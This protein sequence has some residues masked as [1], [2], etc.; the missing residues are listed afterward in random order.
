MTIKNIIRKLRQGFKK[1]K[2]KV[3]NQYNIANEAKTNLELKIKFLTEKAKGTKVNL[4]TIGH[5]KRGKLMN[6]NFICEAKRCET[7]TNS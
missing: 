1:T 5:R 4:R 6:K 3:S 7:K 2:L